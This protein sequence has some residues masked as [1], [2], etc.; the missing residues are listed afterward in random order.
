MLWIKS[1]KR[2]FIIGLLVF[3]ISVSYITTG[4]LNT[5]YASTEPIIKNSVKKVTVSGRSFNVNTV[6]IP[7]GTPV[8]VGLAKGDVGLTQDFNAI[9][10]SYRAEAAINGTFFEAYGGPPDPYGNLIVDGKV[11][12]VGHYGTTIGFK[13]DGTAL[14]DHLRMSIKGKVTRSKGSPSGWYVTFV[15]RTPAVNAN[16]SI[17]Y[18]EN[19]GSRVG[20]KGGIAVVV[21]N[22]IV[23]KKIVNDNV[24]IPKNGYVLVCLGTM[25]SMTERFEVGAVVEM[26]IT[27]E[28][29]KGQAIAWE[30][31]T[32]AVGA[33]PRL[34]K[35]GKVALSPASEGFKDQKI[36]SST[37]ARSGIAIM[38]DGSVI[39]ATV[40]GATMKQWADVMLKMG[41]KHAMNLDGGA[42][43]A[44]YGGGKVLT[45]AGR[46]L[47]NTL[48]FGKTGGS[49]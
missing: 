9:V 27:Y 15:N 7:K 36:L 24:L 5:S 30:D 17:L 21:E 46:L 47:S 44:L 45:P 34:V 12:H 28:N 3:V 35:D 13:A 25:K 16:V 1:K 38:P 4:N 23:V 8:S 10:K 26:N 2:H 48:V 39:I 33:G 31:V 32:T 41:A 29:D 20:F 18:T 14:M 37:A 43:S 42:S 11:A 22:G 6:A 49:S 19:R 40:Q